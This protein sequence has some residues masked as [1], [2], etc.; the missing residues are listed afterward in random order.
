MKIEM[1]IL[2]SAALRVFAFGTS[3]RVWMVATKRFAP[4]S[5]GR[6]GGCGACEVKHQPTAMPSARSGRSPMTRRTIQLD[7]GSVFG[8]NAQIAA[9]GRPRAKWVKTPEAAIQDRPDERGE[10]PESG[11]RL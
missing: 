6:R 2:A 11:H 9:V 4:D 7:A 5:Q 10:A 3:T 8:R 1:N